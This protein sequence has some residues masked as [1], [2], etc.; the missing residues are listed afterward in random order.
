LLIRVVLKTPGGREPDT[1]SPIL[2]R[3][4]NGAG[5][6]KKNLSN[7]FY[8]ANAECPKAH[9]SLVSRL[10]TGPQYRVFIPQGGCRP[11]VLHIRGQDVVV[12]MHRALPA[13]LAFS[14]K[15]HSKGFFSEHQLRYRRGSDGR[16]VCSEQQ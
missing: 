4:S 14:R 1:A 13:H 16:Q 8:R 2:S 12:L 3:D 10:G 11:S 9:R 5:A 15:K 7:A 6:P